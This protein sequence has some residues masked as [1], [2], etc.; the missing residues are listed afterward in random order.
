MA[1]DRVASLRNQGTTDAQH[2]LDAPAVSYHLGRRLLSAA[3]ELLL[4]LLEGKE[5]IPQPGDAIGQT[6]LRK[7]AEIDENLRTTRLFF[8]DN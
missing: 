6:W 1:I 8:F 3:V 4:H 5:E 7:Y 2:S